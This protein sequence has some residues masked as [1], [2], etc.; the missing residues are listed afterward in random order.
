MQ[1]FEEN[2]GNRVIASV[3]RIRPRTKHINIKYWHFVEYFEQGRISIQS[4]KSED[5][6][7]DMLTKPLLAASFEKL[8]DI[9]LEG[10]ELALHDCKGV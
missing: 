9:I 10:K 7:A 6:L 1:G 4:V 8:R 5:Q 3:P 2:K